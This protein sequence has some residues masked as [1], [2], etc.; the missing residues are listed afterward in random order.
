MRERGAATRLIPRAPRYEVSGISWS[1]RLEHRYSPV[2]KHARAKRAARSR[3]NPV[4]HT[5]NTAARLR[6]TEHRHDDE[7]DAVHDPPVPRAGELLRRAA[8]NERVKRDRPQF[9]HRR[10]RARARLVNCAHEQ[11][12]EEERDGEIEALLAFLDDEGEKHRAA[13]GARKEI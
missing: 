3:V 2:R 4:R 5:P 13:T 11:V 10:A 6:R 7:R 12:D 9:L 1:S 8:R